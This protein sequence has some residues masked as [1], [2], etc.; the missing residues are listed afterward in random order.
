MGREIAEPVESGGGGAGV[1][2]G[3]RK[4]T[5]A[6]APRL[7]EPVEPQRGPPQP[8]VVPAVVVDEPLGGV[9]LEDLLAFLELGKRLGRVAKL[10]EDPGE[11]GD[12]M[13]KR[14]DN[15]S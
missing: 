2:R 7:V 6:Q 9:G 14:E 3:I 5:L 8:T 4:R 11:G 10:R 12:S 1:G 15:I 13:G